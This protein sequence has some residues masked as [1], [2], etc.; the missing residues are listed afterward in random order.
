MLQK[1]DDIADAECTPYALGAD[2]GLFYNNAHEL[3]TTMLYNYV[4]KGRES[5]E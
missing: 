4:V 1:C 3:T 5:G 2:D